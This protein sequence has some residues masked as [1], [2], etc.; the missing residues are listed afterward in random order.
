MSNR[1]SVQVGAG[2]PT[3]TSFDGANRPTSDSLGGTYTSDGDGRLTSQPNQRLAWDALGRLTTVYPATGL[4]PLATYTYD[5]LDRLRM[6]DYG[7]TNRVRFRYVGLTTSAAQTIDDQ[8]GS[9]LRNIGTAWGGERQLDWT[10]TNSNIRYYGT[11]AHHDTVWTASST[12]SVSATLRYDPW[13]VLM[14]STG[15]SLPDFRF[16]GSWFDGATALQ[17]VVSRWYAPSLGRFVSED[18]L[19]GSPSDPPSRHLYA[20]AEA[21][22]TNA[23]DADGSTCRFGGDDCYALAMV[24]AAGGWHN[25]IEG[26]RKAAIR[27]FEAR[28]RRLLAKEKRAQRAQWTADYP[29]VTTPIHG[30]TPT[31]YRNFLLFTFIAWMEYSYEWSSSQTG[32]SVPRVSVNGDGISTSFRGMDV[33]INPETGKSTNIGAGPAYVDLGKAGVSKVG[34]RSSFDAQG[35]SIKDSLTTNTNVYGLPSLEYTHTIG[36]DYRFADRNGNP[37]DRLQIEIS[38][39]VKIS[40]R[41]LRLPTRPAP[42]YKGSVED[43]PV[44]FPGVP[45]LTLPSYETPQYVPGMPRLPEWVP[46][47][48]PEFLPI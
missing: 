41:R 42:S 29:H 48:D 30:R 35:L 23:W 45:W 15:A 9:V 3:T 21:N 28:I 43:G 34:F 40:M 27:T 19:L 2:T 7:G 10:G 31:V 47:L 36:G 32:S 5:P 17:W 44:T 26:K 1:T 6:V 4:T 37:T 24:H 39:H 11:N 14:T 16:Q 25:Y 12:G 20:Y 33:R 46:P 8:S 18:S 13:G 22:P 38:S